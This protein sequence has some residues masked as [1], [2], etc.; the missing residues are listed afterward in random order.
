MI[1]S[2]LVSIRFLEISWGRGFFEVIVDEAE[3]LI[4]YHLTEIKSE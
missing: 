4:N 3:V 1:T 2:L